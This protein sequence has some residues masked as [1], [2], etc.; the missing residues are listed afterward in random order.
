MRLGLVLVLASVMWTVPAQAAF[1]G[2]YER[3]YDKR[4]LRKNR[5]QD[6]TKIRLQ[7]GVGGK[8]D[9]PPEYFDQV[10]AVTRKTVRYEGAPIECVARGDDLQCAIEGDGGNF[11]VTDRGQNSLRITNES[12]MRF[13]ND[14]N[15]PTIQGKGQNKEFRLFRI[16]AGPC[17]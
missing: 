3:V 12:F 2:C 4:Y 16:A 6:V 8:A 15:D 14:A 10:F 17:P 7:L 5:K 13:G 1:K 11:T 9:D